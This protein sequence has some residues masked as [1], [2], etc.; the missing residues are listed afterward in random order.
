MFSSQTPLNF[1][2]DVVHIDMIQTSNSEGLLLETLS[3]L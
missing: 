2:T 3:A 1:N